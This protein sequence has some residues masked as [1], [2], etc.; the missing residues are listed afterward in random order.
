[1]VPTLVRLTGEQKTGLENLSARTGA[2]QAYLIRKAVE[3]YLAR[4]LLQNPP[5]EGVGFPKDQ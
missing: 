1:M 4:K 2:S 3:E 5:P